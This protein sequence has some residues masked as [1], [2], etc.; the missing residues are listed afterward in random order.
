MRIIWLPN[1]AFFVELFFQD[2]YYSLER[3]DY[4]KEF[5]I[6]STVSLLEIMY[7]LFKVVDI[8]GVEKANNLDIFGQ[9]LQ[10]SED[11]H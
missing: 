6:K 10:N 7:V 2:S 4:M 5:A 3:Q 8:L 11:A 1:K 9:H